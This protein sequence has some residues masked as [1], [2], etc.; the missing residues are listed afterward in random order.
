ML[1][2][3]KLSVLTTV[4]IVVGT[5]FSINRL[6]PVVTSVPKF[7]LTLLVDLTDITLRCFTPKSSSEIVVL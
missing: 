6:D 5:L 2:I 4:E 1:V 3:K 7:T